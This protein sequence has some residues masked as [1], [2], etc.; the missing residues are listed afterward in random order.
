MDARTDRQTDKRIRIIYHTA[1]PSTIDLRN[2][3]RFMPLY[4]SYSRPLQEAREGHGESF[5]LVVA[6]CRN[7]TKA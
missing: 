3:S 7:S 6:Y 2:K 4:Y 1:V 5:L